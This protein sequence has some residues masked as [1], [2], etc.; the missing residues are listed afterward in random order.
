VDGV[1]NKSNRLRIQY[2]AANEVSMRVG[3]DEV[4]KARQSVKC[5][6]GRMRVYDEL[7]FTGVA[8]YA[9]DGLQKR[10][11]RKEVENNTGFFQR[12]LY[13]MK[14]NSFTYFQSQVWQ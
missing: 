5:Y 9:I 6:I 2:Q 4:L 10:N 7:Y 14:N 11:E 13:T 1:L 8:M 3:W 12:K